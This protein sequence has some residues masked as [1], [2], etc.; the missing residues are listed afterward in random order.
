MHFAGFDIFNRS[1]V[2]S[3]MHFHRVPSPR[4]SISEESGE[5]YGSRA[6]ITGKEMIRAWHEMVKT[7]MKTKR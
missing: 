2:G 6:K 1:W 7:T 3:R 4:L 5:K